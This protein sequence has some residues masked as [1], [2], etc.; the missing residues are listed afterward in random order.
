MEVD[1]E[2]PKRLRQEKVLSQRELARLSGLTQAT[3]WRLEN[4]FHRV[5]P[6]TIRKLAKALEVEPLE[7]VKKEE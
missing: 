1:A 6:K 3:V 2:K 7:L 5:H 4:G